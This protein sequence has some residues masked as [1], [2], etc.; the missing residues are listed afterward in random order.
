MNNACAPGGPDQR[1]AP[2]YEA[3][4]QYRLS[5]VVP[6]DVP[7]HKQGRGAAELRGFLGERCLSVDVNSMKPLDNLMNPVSV[8]REAEELAADAFGASRAFFMVGGTTS[9]VQAMMMSALH[10]GDKVIMPRNVH[11]SAFGALVFT[12]ARPVYVDPGA[13]RALGIPLGMTAS[14]LERA[15]DEHP[16]AKAVFILN[17]TYYGIS[18]PLREIIELTHSR[19]MLALADEAHGTHFY[20]GKELPPAAMRLGADMS[21]IS[22]H[23]TGGSLTQSS[24]LLVG[25]RADPDYVKTVINLTQ[26][27]SPSY[28]LISS[29]DIARR[30]LALDGEKVF[31]EALRLARYARGEINRLGG[32]RAFG[33]DLVE[34][35][36]A[37][38]FDETK[39]SVHTLGTGLAGIEV[40]NILRD[41]YGIQ[42][43]LGD[44]GNILAIVS[45]GDTLANIERLVASLADIKRRFE[46]DGHGMFDH[47]YVTPEVV[48]TPK[49]AFYAKSRRVA[50]EDSQGAV[51]AE[52]LMTYPPG[53]PIFAPGELITR[54]AL[55]HALYARER[56]CLMTGLKD[57]SVA[58]IQVIGD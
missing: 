34:S 33:P 31:S 48:M 12:G 37:A 45:M 39:L 35:G 51:S 6:F 5:R 43:E 24:L 16:D 58:H 52:F 40:Y 26:T 22:M 29:L 36:A 47:E 56:G 8:I 1:R 49:E 19:G 11:K 17:P 25:Q 13:D 57:A 55:E 30:R 28:L 38:A 46:R 32:Y 4:E 7:G 50:L 44:I 2:V 18:P 14:S 9:C 54:D 27:T 10:E 41:D 23:K 53:I 20:F 21:A 15:M 42:I 3:L